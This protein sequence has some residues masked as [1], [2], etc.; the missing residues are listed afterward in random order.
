MVSSLDQYIVKLRVFEAELL[1]YAVDFLA[2]GGLQFVKR[3]LLGF[4]FA[5]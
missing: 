3:R 2:S 4:F 5:W 1:G